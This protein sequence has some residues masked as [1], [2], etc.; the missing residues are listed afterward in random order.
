MGNNRQHDSRQLDVTCTTG[1]PGVN[2]NLPIGSYVCLQLC[3]EGLIERVEDIEVK[4]ATLET[5]VSDLQDETDSGWN[6]LSATGTY[7]SSLYSLFL[8]M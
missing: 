1:N 2:V 8:G 7:S 5:E 3:C 4:V 6:T